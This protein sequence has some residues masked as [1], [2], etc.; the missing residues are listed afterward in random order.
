VNFR[1][2]VAGV[3]RRISVDRVRVQHHHAFGHDFLL[4]S[5]TRTS[6]TLPFKTSEW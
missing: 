4:E 6:K 1:D 3:L 2:A 5:A